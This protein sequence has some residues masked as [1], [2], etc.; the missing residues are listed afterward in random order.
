MPG[1]VFGCRSWKSARGIWCVEAR[2]AGKHPTVLRTGPT[3]KNFLAQNGA[4]VE[5]L[6][7]NINQSQVPSDLKVSGR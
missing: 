5:E 3:M 4:E 7:S 1:N 6:C 2:G